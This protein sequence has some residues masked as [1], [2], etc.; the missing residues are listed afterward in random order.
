MKFHNRLPRL[1]LS[2]S[3]LGFV[4]M[5]GATP[6]FID[7]GGPP[8]NYPGLAGDANTL[9]S[10]FDQFQVFA[11]TTTT[12]FDDNGNGVLDDGE[13]F[14]DRGHLN[15]SSFI[16]S[17]SNGDTSAGGADSEGLENQAQGTGYQITADWMDLEGTSTNPILNSDGTFLVSTITYNS[18]NNSIWDFYFDSTT[19]PAGFTQTDYDG[20]VGKDVAGS[21]T[22]TNGDPILSVEIVGGAGTSLFDVT[23]GAFVSGSSKL[24]AKVVSV[25]SDFWTFGV[26]GDLDYLNSENMKF[27]D[28]LVET[29]FEIEVEIDQNTNNVV[30]RGPGNVNPGDVTDCTVEFGPQ[31]D[32]LFYVDSDH[33]GSIAFNKNA[34][35]EPASL[36]L[37]GGGLLGLAGFGRRRKGA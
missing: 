8:Q 12:Q 13:H 1:V 3:L 6:V 19:N 20:T 23:T 31:C 24:F 36:F 18:T 7:V 30:Q 10:M 5:A 29:I 2:A 16:W 22:F 28:V 32:I 33:D 37:L 4:G 14:T 21:G 26:A 35:P 25:K 27:E 9:T 15:A 11:Q 17:G 34:I